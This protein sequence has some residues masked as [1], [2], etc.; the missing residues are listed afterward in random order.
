ME[1]TTITTLLFAIYFGFFKLFCEDD[2]SFGYSYI[3]KLFPFL[4]AICLIA[5]IHGI[6]PDFAEGTRT[7]YVVKGSYKGLFNKSY[8]GLMIATATPTPPVQQNAENVP[9]WRFSTLDPEM[10]KKIEASEG[11][12]VKIHYREWL[13][14]PVTIDST[15]E[16]TGVENLK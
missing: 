3:S 13:V 6:A 9:T 7:G 1:L 16:V 8:E 11:H 4:L 2:D 5:D 12:F 14:S 10:M 15:Y